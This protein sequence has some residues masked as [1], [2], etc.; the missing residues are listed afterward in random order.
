MNLKRQAMGRFDN[1]LFHASSLGKIMTESRT[2]EP[3]GETAKAHLMQCW[4]EETY[5]REK[6]LTNKYIEKGLAVEEDAI[7]LYSR[8]TKKFMKKNKEQLSN[9]F[10]VGTPDLI[11]GEE[12]VDIKSSWDIFTFFQNIYKPINKTYAWQLSAYCDLLG[13]KSGRLVYCLVDTPPHMIEDA[14]RKLMWQMGVID[15][16]AHPLYLEACEKIDKEMTFADIPIQQRYI[17]FHIEPSDYPIEKAYE[18]IE[19]CRKFMNELSGESIE[20]STAVGA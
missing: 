3:L 13:L 7:T 20:A 1:Y 18:K 14:K 19:L 6:E 8:A 17:D 4:I 12:V 9:N 16:D 5:G 15:P 10:I 11:H 2:K